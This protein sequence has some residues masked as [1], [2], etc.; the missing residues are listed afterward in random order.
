MEWKN[1]TLTRV[2]GAKPV[3]MEDLE[4]WID[5][6]CNK[7]KPFICDTGA[8]LRKAQTEGKQILFEA[9]LG[10]LR[11]LDYGIYP[12]TTS[13]SPLA[14]FGCVGAG[15]SPRDMPDNY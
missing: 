12:Y 1:L 7:I 11:D 10:A 3:T 4:V 6:F 14:G 9:Q 2:Y 5:V 8:F 15:V 13:S